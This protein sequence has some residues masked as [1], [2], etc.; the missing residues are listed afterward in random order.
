MP[1]S[2]PGTAARLAAVAADLAAALE[3][4]DADPLAPLMLLDRACGLT[5]TLSWALCREPLTFPVAGLTEIARTLISA[6]G[7]AAAAAGAAGVGLCP[8]AGHQASAAFADEA[9]GLLLAVAVL[10]ELAG[11]DLDAAVA[12]KAAALSVPHTTAG[13]R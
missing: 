10:A 8:P 9:A 11:I 13:E 7:E 5:E 2:L 3:D 6:P 1:L 4:E 12:R